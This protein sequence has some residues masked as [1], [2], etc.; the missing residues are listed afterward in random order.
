MKLFAVTYRYAPGSE[1]GRDAHRPAHLDFL[2]GLFDDG[3]LVVSGP[4]EGAEPGALLIVRS[5]S[6]EE[7]ERAMTA[8]PF[9][10]HGF[11]ERTVSAWSPKFGS[12]RL[13][14]GA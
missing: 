13:E 12:S 1:Q 4:T 9:A 7:A 6:A 3:T 8:D 11:V 14:A 2:Q 5:G 10:R